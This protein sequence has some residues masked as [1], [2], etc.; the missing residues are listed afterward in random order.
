[1]TEKKIKFTPK[2]KE[3][4]ENLL[5]VIRYDD[6]HPKR[7]SYPFLSVSSFFPYYFNMLNKDTR[8]REPY[9]ELI[10]LILE[11]HL[12][13]SREA[14]SAG[15]NITKGDLQHFMERDGYV[16]RPMFT[17]PFEDLIYLAK[18]KHIPLYRYRAGTTHD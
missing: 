2:Q 16:I 5:A 7:T 3:V 12:D 4:L 8:N 1:M 6:M 18:S 9:K 15:Y 17:L 10:C 11:K 13:K 14:D